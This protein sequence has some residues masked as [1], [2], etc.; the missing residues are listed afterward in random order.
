MVLGW[1]HGWR[2]SLNQS[3]VETFLNTIRNI[4][5]SKNALL[6]PKGIDQWPESNTSV[7]GFID[8]WWIVHDGGM[9]MLIPFLLKQHK[10]WRNCKLRVFTVA[11]MQD[12]SIQMKKDLKAWLY[13]I[14]IEATVEVI[15]FNDSVISQYTYERTLRME[16]RTEMLR[17]MAAA[18]NAARETPSTAASNVA[19]AVRFA[20]RRK[21]SATSND[22]PSVSVDILNAANTPPDSNGNAPTF[23]VS[24]ATPHTSPERNHKNTNNVKR[25]DSDD[26]APLETSK[27]LSLKP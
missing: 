23:T 8:V 10:T 26:Q 7:S 12:N 3:K 11:Q 21:S 9:L 2:Q 24:E 13:A 27:L 25:S 5:S 14:R 4:T 22:P 1:P 19:R 16:Q 15:E 18:A 17:Q 20:T 6:V